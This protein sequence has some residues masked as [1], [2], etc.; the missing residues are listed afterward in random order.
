MGLVE[1]VEGIANF[2]VAVE[3]DADV[4]VQRDMEGLVGL[5]DINHAAMDHEGII[6]TSP[7]RA[8]TTP[9]FGRL[10]FDQGGFLPTGRLR[11][12]TMRHKE[13][14]KEG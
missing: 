1:K 13:G 7:S 4:L 8:G 5:A 14:E 9:V 10:N 6:G 2:A 12:E 11:R 3:A